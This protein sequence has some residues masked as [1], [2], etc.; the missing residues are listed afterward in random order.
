MGALRI[1][2]LAPGAGPF[3][4]SEDEVRRLA[5]AGIAEISLEDLADLRERWRQDGETA[6]AGLSGGAAR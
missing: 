4:L 5:A 3:G 6:R 1:A 2:G